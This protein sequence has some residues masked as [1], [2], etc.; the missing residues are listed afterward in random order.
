[1][2][3]YI[4]DVTVI[5]FPNVFIY[6]FFYVSRSVFAQGLVV[7]PIG[8]PCLMLLS[9]EQRR[10]L[11]RVRGLELSCGFGEEGSGWRES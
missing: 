9:S 3:I 10:F 8:S 6:G 11:S 7:T 4:L 5:V 2:M 1:M